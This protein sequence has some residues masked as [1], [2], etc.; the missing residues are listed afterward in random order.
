VVPFFTFASACI[1]HA[2]E[3]NRHPQLIRS[4]ISGTL[5]GILNW[6]IAGCLGWQKTGL[7]EPVEVVSA[8]EAYKEDMDTLGNWITECC[9]LDPK[10][11]EK[12]SHLYDSYRTWAAG[13][14]TCTKQGIL[15]GAS[16]ARL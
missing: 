15:K 10:K 6:A 7:Q 16:S 8:T 1:P 2:G 13:E 12:A 4:T 5:P 3:R 9:L 14:M 11:R